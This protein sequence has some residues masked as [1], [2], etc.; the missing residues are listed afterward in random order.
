MTSAENNRRI[1]KNTLMLYA[2]M[3]V[4][5]L[6]S[7]Y[8]SRVIL[9]ALGAEDYG[10]YNVV[11]GLVA[12]FSMISSSITVAISRF[13]TFELGSGNQ[14][15]LNSIFSSSIVIQLAICGIVILLAETLGLWFLNSHMSFPEDRAS[16]TNAVYQLSLL[17]FCINLLSSP[18]NS[19]IIAHE[20]MSVYAYVSIFE[21][22]AKLGVALIISRAAGDKLIIYAILL[23]LVAVSVRTYY[24]IY[25]RR[26]FEECK[27]R[28][29]LDKSVLKEMFSYAG[30]TY[31]GASSALL[32]DAGGN[33][34]INIYYGPVA[35][36]ARGIGVQVQQA[37]NQFASNFMTA[38]NPQITKSY[39][40]GDYGYMKFLIF[41]GSRIS[42]YL[43]IF[44]SLPILLNTHYILE[45]WLKQV[46][47]HTVEFV[48]LALVFVIS[49]AI[50]TPLIT[51]ASAAGDIKKYQLLVGGLQSLNF[52]LSLT[53]LILGLPPYITYVVAIVVS[54][55]CLAARL[56]IVRGMIGLSARSFMK[57]VYLNIALVTLA[58]AAVPVLV[59]LKLGETLPHLLLSCLVC[60][61]SMGLS[62]FFVGCGKKE[63]ELAV[64][65]AK[66]A[67]E[68]I[69]GR[70]R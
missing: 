56:Y 26:N 18:Y 11:G 43:L 54:Q 12:M 22:V 7:L 70:R 9:N 10:I 35:N 39:A 15:K 60:V 53:L 29:R 14:E 36:A 42:F 47:P 68:K 28:P 30:W 50:S 13:L 32:R 57:N 34:L 1:A 67:Y 24:G 8:T 17:T 44:L 33:I 19:A 59:Q 38:V 69:R 65:K 58:G 66:E 40:S 6:V 49:E 61:I 5:M 46:P 41:N 20:R 52:P 2:R 64:G 23:A 55:A 21:A 3:L 27:F 45:L 37:V 31:I 62:I 25:C 48:R 51:S 16:A 63:R 4:T